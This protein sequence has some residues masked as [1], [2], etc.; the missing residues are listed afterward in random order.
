MQDNNIAKRQKN[1]RFV[2]FNNLRESFLPASVRM[3]IAITWKR[4]RREQALS[5]RAVKG[6]V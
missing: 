1:R 2:M 6:P 4:G 3:R 5:V